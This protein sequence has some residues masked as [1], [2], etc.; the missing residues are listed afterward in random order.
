[1]N[2]KDHV[3]WFQLE[4]EQALQQFYEDF[5][6]G[7]RP[8]LVI[9]AP[10]QHG[11]SMMVIDFISWLAGKSPD[12]RTIYTSFSDRLGVRANLKLQR[13]YNSGRYK[14]VFPETKINSRESAGTSGEATRNREL[15]E[16]VDAEGSF[17]NT[18]VN[19]SI[20]GEGLDLGVMDD[21]VKGRAAAGSKAQRDK[22]WDWFTDDFFTRFAESAGLLAIMTRWH[23]DDVI[24]RFIAA[25]PR[26]KV[27]T[28]KALA[29]ENEPNRKA[30]EALFP[31]LKT[32]EFLLERKGL[33]SSAH[34]EALYQQSPTQ[35]GGDIIQGEWFRRYRVLP[36]IKY[37][38]IYADTAQKTGE[39]NDYSVLECWGHAVDGG[40]YLIDLIR[41]KWKAPELKRRTIAF[42][43][44]HKAIEDADSTDSMGSLRSLKIEDKSS[45]TGLIQDIQSTGSIPVLGIQRTKDKYTRVDDV[46]S[47]IEAG[48]VYIPESAAWV[49][50]FVDECEAFTADDS[51]M[52]DDQIDPMVDAINDMLA[53]KGSIYDNL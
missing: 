14:A 46:V 16:Y 27:L 47:Y 30:G 8:K 4:A 28:F 42:W 37:R 36:K 6:A 13:I 39:R 11:K 34:W 23:L 44:K 53:G 1:M 32:R 7:L 29:T 48:R 9:Q 2:P 52:H 21:P 43:D 45:G 18:T 40:V 35:E 38:I 12:W 3:G 51:H 10:P 41:G 33:M 50:D 24:G 5:I 31:E 15:L 17:R 19:G 26:V 49:S 20:N 25:D 22:T